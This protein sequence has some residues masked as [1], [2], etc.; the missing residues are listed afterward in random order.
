[1][2]E[3]AEDGLAIAALGL[4]SC[5]AFAGMTEGGG[6][7]RKRLPRR[8]AKFAWAKSPLYKTE[9][10]QKYNVPFSSHKTYEKCK[11]A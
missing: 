5:P 3:A 7:D 11:I 1:M 4:A 6:D 10:L 2:A 8:C 9:R